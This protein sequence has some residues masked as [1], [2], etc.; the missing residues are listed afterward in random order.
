LKPP[1]LPDC[2]PEVAGQITAFVLSVSRILSG[3]LRGVYLHG[4][5]ALGCFNAAESDVDTLTR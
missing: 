4:S 2:P 1:E 5:L 3:N